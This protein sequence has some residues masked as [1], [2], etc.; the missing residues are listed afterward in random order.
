VIVGEEEEGNAWLG[1]DVA[2][3]RGPS[4]GGCVIISHFA[5]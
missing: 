3:E 1:K 5:C 4:G 2:A